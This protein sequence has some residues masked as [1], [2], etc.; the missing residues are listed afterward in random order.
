MAAK[1]R[2]N[3]YAD[4]VYTD[5]A[6]D[7]HTDPAELSAAVFADYAGMAGEILNPE[8]ALYTF[9]RDN[10]FEKQ[11]N[12]VEN[13]LDRD[14][15]FEDDGAGTFD[16]MKA[17]VA[18][19]YMAV[20][21]NPDLKY[22]LWTEEGQVFAENTDELLALLG[23]ELFPDPA[24]IMEGKAAPRDMNPMNRV[25]LTCPALQVWIGYSDPFKAGRIVRLMG[26]GSRN[27]G[28]PFYNAPSPYRIAYELS[29]GADLFFNAD[30]DSPH[31]CHT[32]AQ[33]GAYL[34]GRLSMMALNKTDKDAF[35]DEFVLIEDSAVAD[36]CRARGGELLKRLRM[37]LQCMDAYTPENQ[38]KPFPY[39]YV[40]GAYK[41]V[42]V[43]R[44]HAPSYPVNGKEITGPE[45]LWNIHQTT[46][47]ELFSKATAAN[48]PG[49]ILAQL[50][51]QNGVGGSD[52]DEEGPLPD[53]SG[54]PLPW[55]YAWMSV[56]FQENPG[57]NVKIPGTYEGA[58]VRYLESAGRFFPG[59]RYYRR[60]RNA[61]GRFDRELKK[62]R[63]SS[64]RVKLTQW[65]WLLAATIPTLV[66][67]IATF[68]RGMSTLYFVIGLAVLCGGIAAAVPLLGCARRFRCDAPG[69]N[70]SGDS[71]DTRCLEALGYAFNDTELSGVR[72]VADYCAR[73]CAAD[74][75]AVRAARKIG[76]Q[77]ALTAWIVAVLWFHFNPAF[78][79]ISLW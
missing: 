62:L 35:M 40:V 34:N 73:Q 5:A 20:L 71:R 39:N 47:N 41:A 43:F 59:N 77:W 58:T 56:F 1:K 61:M 3:R 64:R 9:Y 24:A 25:L 19:Y 29:E 4:G 26:E 54:K 50:A 33:V 69:L 79:E 78:G 53:G 75:D 76:L 49:R 11:A 32:A 57:L 65:L 31:R 7:S 60:Y 51:R 10:G 16:G 22:P 13:Y 14:F 70:L 36:Y 8:S 46:R 68:S 17:F 18:A 30:P 74:R 12:L 44:G 27:P 15:P 72:A 55:L 6:G 63:P 21:L 38:S 67:G 23:A 52:S 42:A 48:G 45:Q 37:A 66:V 2:K 28:D